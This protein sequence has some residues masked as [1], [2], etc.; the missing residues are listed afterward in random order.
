MSWDL[1]DKDGQVRLPPRGLHPPAP[2]AL[3]PPHNRVFELRLRHR[4]LYGEKQSSS[5][6]VPRAWMTV[7]CGAPAF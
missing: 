3:Q 4:Y 1:Y 2:A 7:I 5:A 6:N